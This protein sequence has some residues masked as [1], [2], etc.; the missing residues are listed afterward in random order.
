[1]RLL[2]R[3]PD[4]GGFSLVSRVGKDIPPYAILSHTWDSDNDEVTF[5]EISEGEGKG[6]SGYRKLS[7]CSKQ[8]ARDAL[9]FFWVDTCC[10]E[11][12]SSAELSEAINSMFKWY[13]KAEKCYV[14]LTD[15]TIDSPTNDVSPQKCAETFRHSR[16]FKRGWTLQELLA[17]RSVEFFSKDEDRIG[18]KTTLLQ[19]VHITT[20]IPVAAL[21]GTPLSHF[22]VDERMSWAKDRE[23]K[24]EEDSAYSLF[25][26]FDV[27]LPLLYGEGRKKAMVRL[28]REIDWS[29]SSHQL[30]P[31]LAPH[32]STIPFKRDD[33]FIPR[34]SLERVCQICAQPASRAALVGLRGIG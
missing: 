13:Q 19:A 33:D 30:A 2:Q 23:T 21:R 29:S 18:D 4:D 5:K 9:D 10:I 12:T 7:F 1:M 8:A 27:Q 28:R 3:L 32:Y 17:S 22:T 34:D 24:H 31:P 6:K 26:I 16:W 14:F 15:V 25:G 20:R 11:K